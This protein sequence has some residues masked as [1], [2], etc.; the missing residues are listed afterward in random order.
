MDGALEGEGLLSILF[1]RLEIYLVS[2]FVGLL[3]DVAS[4]KKN[5]WY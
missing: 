4:R 5:T 1:F 2:E 3:V